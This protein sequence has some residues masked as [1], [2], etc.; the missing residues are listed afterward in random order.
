MTLIQRSFTFSV[1]FHG[2]LLASAY[3]VLPSLRPDIND[4]EEIIVVEMVDI[5]ELTNA[6]RALPE[7]EEKPEPKKAVES[8]PEPAPPP[9]EPVVK[10]PEPEP[11]PPPVESEPEVAAL[12]PEPEPEPEEKPE[13]EPVQ[14]PEAP[15]PSQALADAKPKKKPKPPDPFASVLKTLEDLKK[16]VPV[17]KKEEPEE[18]PEKDEDKKPSFEEQIAQALQVTSTKAAD[19][20]KPISIS[21]REAVAAQ[22]RRCWIVPAG[23]KNAE[24]LVISIHV[25]MNPDATVRNSSIANMER[26]MTDSFYRAAAESALRATKNPRC[27][28]LPLP[29]DQY[30]QWRTMT[31]NFNPQDML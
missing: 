21:V 15:Q 14:K 22:L 24:E 6:P 27:Q 7:P 10:A 18:K 25:D 16:Q 8:E 1:L 11:A 12:P 30:E 19:T 23:A 13:P 2:F 4:A 17:E 28:P 20:S 26:A 3:V 31:L 29:L 5:A 9:P